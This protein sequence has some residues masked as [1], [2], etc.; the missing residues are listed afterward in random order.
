MLRR[1]RTHTALLTPCGLSG[2]VNTV[3]LP[4]QFEHG[5]YSGS[6]AVRRRG[7][8]ALAC[9]AAGLMLAREVALPAPAW[10]GMAAAAVAVALYARGRV[11]AVALALAAV[12]AGGGVMAARV[13]APMART[14]AIAERGAVTALLRGRVT[15]VRRQPGGAGASGARSSLAFSLEVEEAETDGGPV[16]LRGAVR[17]HVAEGSVE[18]HR[19]PR[20][21]DALSVR[22]VFVPVAG[23]MNP[24]ERDDR[25]WAAEEGRLGRMAAASMDLVESWDVPASAGARASAWLGRGL[26]GLRS[27]A[28]ALLDDA[29]EAPEE[30]GVTDRA[31]SEGV[32]AVGGGPAASDGR[33]DARA[34]L[35]ALLLGRTDPGLAPLTAAM[36]RLGQVHVLSISGFHLSV[37]ALMSLFVVRL[38]GDRGRLEP[39]IVAC[40]V[41]LYLLVVPAQAPVLR[42]GLMVLA[43][44]AA[45]ATGRRYDR[46]NVMAYIGIALL[47]WRPMDLWTPGFQ[48]SFGVTAVLLASARGFHERLFPRGVVGTRA[49]AEARADPGHQSAW[50]WVWSGCTGLVSTSVLCWAVATPVVMYHVGI[51]S[52]LAF[53]T[54]VVLVPVFTVLLWVGF[55]TLAAGLVWPALA[56]WSGGALL[57]IAD[58]AVWITRVLDGAGWM[59]VNMPAVSPLW[60]AGATAVVLHW[61]ERGSVRSVRDWALACLV[62]GWL[63]TTL[64]G[65]GRAPAGVSLRVDALAVGDGSAVVLRSGRHAVLWAGGGGGGSRAGGAMRIAVPRAARALGAWRVRTAVVPHADARGLV[66]LPEVARAMGVTLVLV[67]SGLLTMAEQVAGSEAGRLVSRLRAEGVGLEALEAGTRVRFGEAELEIQAVADAPGA[68]LAGRVSAPGAAGRRAVVLAD[69]LSRMQLESVIERGTWSG[70]GGEVHAVALPGR[71]RAD[72]SAWQHVE[73]WLLTAGV[74]VAWRSE[75][76]RLDGRGIEQVSPG[77]FSTARDGAV[78]V[79][80]RSDGGIGAGA[81]T[82]GSWA[83]AARGVVS[84]DPGAAR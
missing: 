39:V 44:L 52:P 69:H 40:L 47:A 53:A 33:E 56:A 75:A 60:A 58:A 28:H 9:F 7:V 78:W 84:L 27:R 38:T 26:D 74:A 82:P 34:L 16:P 77:R 50:G 3:E 10:F 41:G 79:E 43:L 57:A 45:E 20:I 12:C 35:R 62:L 83:A 48:L 73:R 17:V 46:V 37:M 59:A 68:A 15:E 71:G 81:T 66:E 80:F 49:A 32:A 22:G 61:C 13:L 30:D 11:C 55:G 18:S 67:P 23:P 8:A 31:L 1:A 21:G 5:A 4:N 42:S 54:S 70:D 14:E 64:V 76:P 65:A 72:P 29:L 19:V 2:T 36:S 24:G 51:V 25:L 63:A 6:R